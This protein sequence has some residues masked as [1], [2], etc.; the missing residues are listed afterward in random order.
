VINSHH[1]KGHVIE[2]EGGAVTACRETGTQPIYHTADLGISKAI[3][4]AKRAIDIAVS[5]HVAQKLPQVQDGGIYIPTDKAQLSAKKEWM[6]FYRGPFYDLDLLMQMR[7]DFESENCFGPIKI[8][9]QD[10]GFNLI[11]KRG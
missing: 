4:E 3:A 9:P 1:Y 2:V 6:G 11:E 7:R 5:E 8:C 10:D